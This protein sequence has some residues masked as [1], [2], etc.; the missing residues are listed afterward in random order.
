MDWVLFSL[1]FFPLLAWGLQVVCKTQTVV[2]WTIA[3]HGGRTK[4]GQERRTAF[5]SQH[6]GD[7]VTSKPPMR[8]EL[9]KIS[10]NYLS[11]QVTW[12]KIYFKIQRNI[13]AETGSFASWHKYQWPLETV[14]RPKMLRHIAR[15][16][17]A[18]FVWTRALIFHISIELRASLYFMFILVR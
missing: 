2:K 12:C 11:L 14:L 4:W 18:V 10:M 8:L 3:R 6:G 7:D 15:L 9:V 16:R 13:R 17:R 1:F 5:V